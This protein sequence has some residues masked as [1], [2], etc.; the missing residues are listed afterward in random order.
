MTRSATAKTAKKERGAGS[1]AKER[2]TPQKYVEIRLRGDARVGK[3]Y[4]AEIDE[5]IERM[6]R[7]QKEIERLRNKTRATLERLKAA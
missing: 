6:R 3:T 1:V 5:V 4:L 2:G 7:D